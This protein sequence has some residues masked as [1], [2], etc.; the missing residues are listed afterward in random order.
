M[1][2]GLT[3]FEKDETKSTSHNIIRNCLITQAGRLHPAAIGVWVGHSPHN[4]IEHNEISDLYY[5]GIS[6]GWS[7]GY[8]PAGAHHNT[9]AHNHVHTIGQGVLSDMG[10]I[11]TLGLSEGTSIRHNL[12]HD[13]LSFDY[14]GWGIYFDEGTTHMTAENN[15]VY[16]TR[17]GG[18][19]QHYG[20][21]NVVRNNIFANSATDQIQRTRPEPHL[22]FTFERNIVYWTTGGKLLGSNWGDDKFALDR[23][24]YWR[25]DGK[26]FDFAGM[27]FEDWRAR[28]SR[29]QT[30]SWRIRSS[31]IRRRMTFG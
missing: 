12:F 24:V 5:T 29:T 23:N 13:I 28:K 19:H 17:T 22:S 14:G 9:I 25:A 18:F 3:R 2:I 10:G 6:L 20:K 16:N 4:V 27:S 21:E 8:D 1:K 11:Y 31:S 7:W 30:Q 15:V 26:P